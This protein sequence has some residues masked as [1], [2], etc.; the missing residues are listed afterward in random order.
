MWRKRSS[1]WTMVA[2]EL[3]WLSRPKRPASRNHGPHSNASI[4]TSWEAERLLEEEFGKKY[5]GE[6]DKKKPVVNETVTVDSV[7]ATVILREYLA[8]QEEPER[9]E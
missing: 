7:A 1:A 8:R 9:T 4:E 2:H 6:S 3:D 5:R